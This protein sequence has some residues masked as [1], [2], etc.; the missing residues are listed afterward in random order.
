MVVVHVGPRDDAEHNSQYQG[1]L[2]WRRVVLVLD[3]M[4][5]DGFC[6][7]AVR[8]GTKKC[9]HQINCSSCEPAIR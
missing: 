5:R 6:N 9:T 7:K 4:V 3:G 2:I 8:H 1:H